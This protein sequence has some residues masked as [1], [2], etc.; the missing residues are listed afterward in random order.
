MQ[1]YLMTD[2]NNFIVYAVQA[3]KDY[4]GIAE[5]QGN[6]WQKV[7]QYEHDQRRHLEDLVELLGKQHCNLE[8][9]IR[10]SLVPPSGGS[11][12]TTGGRGGQGEHLFHFNRFDS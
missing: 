5:Q 8:N 12:P 11:D 7:V 9:K 4:V 2:I 10:R 3:C 6:R 1:I